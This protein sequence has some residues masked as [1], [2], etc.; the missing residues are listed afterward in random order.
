MKNNARLFYH[1]KQKEEALEKEAKRL[2]FL[3]FDLAM[4]QR[5]HEASKKEQEVM[6]TAIKERLENTH[7]LFQTKMENLNSLLTLKEEGWKQKLDFS[8]HEQK[9]KDLLHGEEVSRLNHTMEIKDMSHQNERVLDRIE[10]QRELFDLDQEIAQKMQDIYL[11]QR[12]LQDFEHQLS[13]KEGELN[14]VREQNVL[15]NKKGQILQAMYQQLSKQ[16]EWKEEYLERLEGL[17]GQEFELKEKG[18]KLFLEKKG[19]DFEMR[20]GKLGLQQE[21]M[22][23]R[24][25]TLNAEKYYNEAYRKNIDAAYSEM[26]ADIL[27]KRQRQENEESEMRSKAREWYIEHSEKLSAR[28]RKAWQDKYNAEKTFYS[29]WKKHN[30]LHQEIDSLQQ[31]E[32][33]LKEQ[34]NFLQS[35]A[36][37]IENHKQRL[38]SDVQEIKNQLPAGKT[39]KKK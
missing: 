2:E 19:F 22:E 37:E 17:K 11:L 8:Q 25:E 15:E 4:K 3:G 24:K 34:V 9:L 6:L 38:L 16:T 21:K 10:Q 26:T 13:F 18:L 33:R 27:L 14:L 7:I 39:G 31:Q 20:E 12:D 1:M 5:E 30:E 36:Q 23:A 28:Q 35:R 29:F 32:Q